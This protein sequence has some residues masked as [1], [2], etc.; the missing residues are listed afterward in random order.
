MCRVTFAKH[1][2]M[3]GHGTL[4]NPAGCN[5][6]LLTMFS[7]GTV[8]SGHHNVR[9]AAGP[10]HVAVLRPARACP[11]RASS[12]TAARRPAPRIR[13]LWQRAPRLPSVPSAKHAVAS[14]FGR[15]WCRKWRWSY[16]LRRG[17]DLVAPAACGSVPWLP[18]RARCP[19]PLRAATAAGP[20]PLPLAVRHGLRPPCVRRPPPARDRCCRPLT[21]RLRPVP[22]SA[23]PPAPAGAA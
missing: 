13:R 16:V 2:R 18:D 7:V 9:A 10:R 14:I 17:C 12:V 23:S 11:H 5:S 8:R 20:R 15:F 3:E 6:S 19:A 21:A 22:A 4:A 1:A